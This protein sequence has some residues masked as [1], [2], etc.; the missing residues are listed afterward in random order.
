MQLSNIVTT[1]LGAVAALQGSR[2]APVDIVQNDPLPLNGICHGTL[3]A[4]LGARLERSYAQCGELILGNPRLFGDLGTNEVEALCIAQAGLETGFGHA[5]RGRP[6]EIPVIREGL[7]R[8]AESRADNPMLPPATA[9]HTLDDLR[10]INYQ[11]YRASASTRYKAQLERQVA[12]LSAHIEPHHLTS[13]D[14][15]RRA[16]ARPACRRA[17]QRELYNWLRSEIHERRTLVTMRAIGKPESI[18]RDQVDAL[19]AE[20]VQ[21]RFGHNA[22][23]RRMHED[24]LVALVQRSNGD[25]VIP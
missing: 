7:H 3:P 8:L 15:A 2:A 20:L 10:Q 22:M 21:L 19:R 5:L 4:A 23:K 16:S 14:D 1:L 17:W 9:G 11:D 13:L 18:S 25:A 12:V 24:A 6:S